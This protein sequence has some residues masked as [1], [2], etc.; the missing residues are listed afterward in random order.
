MYSTLENHFIVHH[1]RHRL[2]PFCFLDESFWY[3]FRSL[4]KTKGAVEGLSEGL[5]GRLDN[6]THLE[7]DFRKV[8][9]REMDQ[10]SARVENGVSQVRQRREGVEAVYAT[11]LHVK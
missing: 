2:T 9:K 5:R 1:H 8:F 3:D 6:A 7:R 4:N 11:E 10:I